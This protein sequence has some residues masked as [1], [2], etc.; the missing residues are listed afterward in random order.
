M[1]YY[2]EFYTSCYDKRNKSKKTVSVV[3]TLLHLQLSIFVS[4]HPL[5]KMS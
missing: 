5:K 1:K 4:K 2:D 3:S